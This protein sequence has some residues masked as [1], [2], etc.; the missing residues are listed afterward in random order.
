[1]LKTSQTGIELIKS[2][3][4]LRLTAYKAVPTE[5]YYTIGYGHYGPDVA[6]DAVITTGEAETYLIGD[7]ATAELCVN[8][9]GLEL[10][11]NEFDALVSFTFNCGGANLKSSL[12]TA[13]S[14]RSLTLCFST[15]RPAETSLKASHGVERRRGYCLPP[16]CLK[17]SRRAPTRPQHGK[18]PSPLE[19]L[20][21][22]TP[23][24]L[25]PGSRSL[26]FCIGRVS[27][28]EDWRDCQE[29][30]KD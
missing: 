14:L 26:H 20:T 28:N 29:N 5:K 30:N 17:R 16:P 18:R 4:G 3:E 1:M 9:C 15:T 7:L 11:Q 23:K 6:A 2:F 13:P 8:M 12:P 25:A 19:S 21:A 22:A 24:T 27:S 10:N